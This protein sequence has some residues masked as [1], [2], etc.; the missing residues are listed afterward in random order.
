MSGQCLSA[1]AHLLV[2]YLSFVV[3]EGAE[4]VDDK[5]V[6]AMTMEPNVRYDNPAVACD[7]PDEC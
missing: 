1:V 6:M 3:L 2:T 5:N 7:K 4:P